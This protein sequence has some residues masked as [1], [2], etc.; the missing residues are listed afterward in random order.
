MIGA[1]IGFNSK[2]NSKLELMKI[3]LYSYLWKKKINMECLRTQI[4]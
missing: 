3:K 2:M 4:I 1:I